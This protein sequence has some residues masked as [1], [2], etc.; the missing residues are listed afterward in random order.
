M[1]KELSKE[2][3]DT[4]LQRA[5]DELGRTT[6]YADFTEAANKRN[7]GSP[8][9]LLNAFETYNGGVTA[10]EAVSAAIQNYAPEYADLAWTVC[11]GFWNM[12]SKRG[13]QDMPSVREQLQ[14]LDTSL[15]KKQQP[16][17]PD[18][19]VS[20]EDTVGRPE[21]ARAIRAVV[22]AFLKGM[23]LTQGQPVAKYCLQVLATWVPANPGD[24]ALEY[25]LTLAALEEICRL[26][27]VKK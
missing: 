15:K 22:G 24:A 14:K 11:Y 5:A 4:L 7:L 9:T 6:G 12:P 27:A 10:E 20:D 23:Q 17:D 8:R 1:L 13:G 25:P 2:G 26:R 18:G 3:R 16:D 21:A 19:T